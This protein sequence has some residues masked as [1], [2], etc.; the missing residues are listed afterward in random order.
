MQR[1]SNFG[2]WNENEHSEKHSVMTNSACLTNWAKL[3]NAY[4]DPP[5]EKKGARSAEERRGGAMP[6]NFAPAIDSFL[7]ESR[8]VSLRR[9]GT[10]TGAVQGYYT[11]TRDQN[12][13]RCQIANQY[14]LF[15]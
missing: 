9:T 15:Y 10:T 2:L 14:W 6:R 13:C 5:E 3:L 7:D 4:V 11:C 12:P 8:F 1:C